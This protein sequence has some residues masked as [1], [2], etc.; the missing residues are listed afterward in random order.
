MMDERDF[1][2]IM[3]AKR[4]IHR[5]RALR[6]FLVFGL[7]F[8]A[9]LRMMG[10]ELPF[11]YLLLFVLLLISLIL[12]SDLIANFGMVSKHDLISLIENHIHN[13]PDVLARYS[14]ARSRS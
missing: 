8:S 12:S 13:D 3:R 4:Q 11:M 2:L 5:E 7:F 6:S 1:Q 10:V 14:N 9:S